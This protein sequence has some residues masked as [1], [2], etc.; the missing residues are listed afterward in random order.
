MNRLLN[1]VNKD[2]NM[3]GVGFEYIRLDVDK[4]YLFLGIIGVVEGLVI[5]K[6]YDLQVADNELLDILENETLELQIVGSW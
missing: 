2:F 4:N 5:D 1:K 6:Y 3:E